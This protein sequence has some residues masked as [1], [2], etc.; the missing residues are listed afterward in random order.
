MKGLRL[1]L[2][3]FTRLP[4]GTHPQNGESI[5]GAVPWFP[6]VGA[7]V[8]ALTGGAYQR[9]ARAI[10]AQCRK[11]DIP[12]YDL[13]KVIRSSEERG[14]RLYWNYDSHMSEAGYAVVGKALFDWT[15][16][17]QKGWD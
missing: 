17:T 10:A 13:T 5:A 8:G 9:H 14:E 11:L 2:A 6:V 7:L 15:A 4:G 1:A 16:E 12:F 3:F